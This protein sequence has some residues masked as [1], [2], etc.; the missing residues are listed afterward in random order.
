VQGIFI[1]VAYA[2]AGG[3]TSWQCPQHAF[4]DKLQELEIFKSAEWLAVIDVD[5]FINIHIGSCRLDDLISSAGE[6]DV[7]QL[8][9]AV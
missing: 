1:P 2:K 8:N 4:Y 9:W 3:Q 6:A 5:E 7:I